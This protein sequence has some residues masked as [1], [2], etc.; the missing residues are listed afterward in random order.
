[1]TAPALNLLQESVMLKLNETIQRH[2]QL[3]Y[4]LG[5]LDIKQARE[6]IQV[7]RADKAKFFKFLRQ[8]TMHPHS[9]HCQDLCMSIQMVVKML[10]KPRSRDGPTKVVR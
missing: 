7:A 4:E 9:P 1:M 10:N 6:A 2:L 3:Q 8:T 5:N